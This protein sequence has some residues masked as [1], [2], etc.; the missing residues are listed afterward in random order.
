[1]E[2]TFVNPIR[3][4]LAEKGLIVGGSVACTDPFLTELMGGIYDFLWIDWEH[5]ALDRNHIQN[6]LIAAKAA[7]TPVVVRIPW[8]DPVLAKPILEMGIDGIVFPQI[9]SVEEA[10]LAI[11][12]CI[13]PPEGIRGYGPIRAALANHISGLDYVREVKERVFRILQ[14]E[15]IDCVNC[16]DEMLSLPGLDAICVGPM[17]LTASMGKIGQFNDPEVIRVFDQIGQTAAKHPEVRMMISCGYDESFLAD[18]MRRGVTILHTGSEVGHILTAGQ[19]EYA[20]VHQLARR[21]TRGE[22]EE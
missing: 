4:A 15:H 5:T 2:S 11:A 8:N 14:V 13:Y 18:W 19:A 16:L 22:K 1:M 17:D 9:R 20:A 3:K 6:H 12:S 10:K 7:R 21:I